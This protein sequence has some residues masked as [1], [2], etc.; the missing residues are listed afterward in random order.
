MLYRTVQVFINGKS[1]AFTIAFLNAI[2]ELRDSSLKLSS[3]VYTR[4]VETF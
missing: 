1:F 3:K 2:I 4:G